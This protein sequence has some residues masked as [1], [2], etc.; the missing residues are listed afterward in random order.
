VA[1][2]TQEV[3]LATKVQVDNLTSG[4]DNLEGLATDH[5]LDHTK[6]AAFDN[7]AKEIHILMASTEAKQ[8]EEVGHMTE[9]IQ[10]GKVAGFQ[11]EVAV[12]LGN[13]AGELQQ[14]ETPKTQLS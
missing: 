10:V 7:Q 11:Q 4:T 2:A 12:V 14:L 6:L 3:V 9:A 8:E 1:Y 13:L 5:I